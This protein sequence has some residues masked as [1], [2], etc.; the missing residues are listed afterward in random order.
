MIINYILPGIV[1]GLIRGAVG[2][3][4]SLEKNKEIR[5]HKVLFTLITSAIVGGAAAALSGGDWRVSLLA[6]YAGTDFIE[7]LYQMMVFGFLFK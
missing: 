4:K 2:I 6:G 3:S 5:L 1:G 7:G